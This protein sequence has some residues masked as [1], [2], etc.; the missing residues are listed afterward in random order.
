MCCGVMNFVRFI[1]MVIIGLL[2]SDRSRGRR[3]GGVSPEQ[4]PSAHKSKITNLA[5]LAIWEEASA[6]VASDLI[7]DRLAKNWRFRFQVVGLTAMI[8]ASITAL[9]VGIAGY[10]IW[11]AGKA[12]ADSFQQTNMKLIGDANA[13]IQTEIKERL[14]DK[15]VSATLQEI[16]GN[17]SK[18]LLAETVDPSIKK[19]ETR[20]NLATAEA[21]KQLSA[22]RESFAKQ[23]ND[24]IQTLKERN[25]I[26]ALADKAISQGDVEAYRELEKMAKDNDAAMSE[27]LG[28]FNAFSIFSAKR[29]WG[30]GLVPSAFNS[31]KT[32]EEELEPEEIFP[33]FF[34]FESFKGRVRAMELM[35][36]KFRR[37]SYSQIAFLE[38]AVRRETNLYALHE[39]QKAV[40]RLIGNETWGSMDG[41]DFLKWVEENRERLKKEDTD[42]KGEPNP[43]R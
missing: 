42:K 5:D 8:L 4:D 9:F 30:V 29:N 34:G 2:L 21:E 38:E 18:A 32:K 39:M 14:D 37:G 16:V 20:L 25:R 10:G 24:E 1:G 6:R 40:P 17:E 12:Q 15:N 36:P 27:L 43:A 35:I 31:K 13:K 19:F 3:S 22:V 41:R 26:T 23:L 33:L 11:Q 7:A 28:V